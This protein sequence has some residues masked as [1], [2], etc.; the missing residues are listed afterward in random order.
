MRILIIASTYPRHEHDY[1]VPWLRESVARLA[2][3]GHDIEILAPSFE[4]I[5]D[6]R[7][8]GILVH[9]F[10]YS[11]ARWEHLTHEQGAPNR[12]RNPLYEILGAPYF[13]MGWW[14]ARRVASQKR[15][16]I[17][18]AHWPFPH[19]PM[20]LAAAKVCG[21][22]TVLT[23]HGAEFALA[24][25]KAWIRPLLRRSLQRADLLLAN[26]SWTAREIRELSGREAIV[27][28]FGATV[29]A[30]VAGQPAE[31][32]QDRPR[33]LFTGRLIQR[34]GVEYLLRAVPHVLRKQPAEFVIT[35]DGDE[36]LRLE[37]LARSLG[38][39][40]SVRFVG[41]VSN[42]QLD[43]EYA[44]CDVWV[45]PAIVDDRGDTEGLGVGAIDAYVHRKSVVASAVGGIP[46]VVRDG[47][48][49][50]LV[51][52]K[53]EK[54]LAEAILELLEQPA[55]A[56]QMAEAGLQLA[57]E[58]FDWNRITDRLEGMYCSLLA[59]RREVPSG[60]ESSETGRWFTAERTTDGLPN[61]ADVP[62][63]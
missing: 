45:N 63:V 52:E 44:S 9:R 11:P 34:K 3:R 25:R 32:R 37:E 24:R 33:I 57:R 1:A 7:V 46:D 51:P 6:H 16:D 12:I 13:I 55:R 53:D 61:K 4:G 17:V 62:T 18:H 50:L 8:D 38:I 15:F 20:A 47:V 10:R 5:A 49:G 35:G 2:G 28:P 40:D 60:S 29:R 59:G 56:A 31:W 22:R 27:L 14:A 19:G 36:R 58:E 23:S 39:H 48:T 43:A 30:A 26:S 41:F 54:R 21:A 42:D